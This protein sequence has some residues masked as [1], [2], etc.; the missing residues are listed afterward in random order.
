MSGRNL[1]SSRRAFS[2]RTATCSPAAVHG[3]GDGPLPVCRA[4]WLLL[5]PGGSGVG[6]RQRLRARRERAHRHPALHRRHDGAGQVRDVLDRAISA[7][8]DSFYLTTDLR[9]RRGHKYLA[10]TPMSHMSLMPF[11]A[12][13]SAVARPTR[14]TR[15]T[16][17]SGARPCSVSASR[18]RLLVNPA[19]SAARYEQQ[20][21]VRPVVTAHDDLRRGADRAG[22]GRTPGRRVRTDLRADLWC[23]RNHHVR[24]GAAQA[25]APSDTEAARRGSLPPAACPRGWS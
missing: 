23:E 14:S 11:V 8:R 9:L 12:T 16:S 17:R 6:R 21:D 19:V 25:R 20:Q 1:Y 18:N 5:G 15:P 10:F 3:G 2:P 24:L 7:M 22:S 4:T 13:S